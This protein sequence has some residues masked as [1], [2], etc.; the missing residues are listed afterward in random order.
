V[1]TAG[2]RTPRLALA[3]R[4]AQLLDCTLDV[5]T[6]KGFAAVNIEAI[7]RRA[8]V[9]RP[10]IYDTFG[11]L[12]TLLLALI[13]RADAA[14]HL[15]LHGILGSDPP[16]GADPERF[17]VDSVLAFL[18]AVRS[19]PRTWRLVLMPPR[20]DSP[21]LQTRIRLAR[22]E[23]ADRVKALLDW[24]V[25]SL[26][27]PSGLD[28]ELLARLIVAASE[29]A[30]R[31]MLAHPRR[32]PPERLAA[33]AR[34]LVALVPTSGNAAPPP[35]AAAPLGP[36]GPL[37]PLP[38]TAPP[39]RPDLSATRPAG[40]PGPVTSRHRVPQPERREQLLD[41]TLELLAEGGF[42]ALSVE[43]IARGTGVNRVVVY[44]SFANL[45]VLLTALMHREDRR[46][47]VTL[48]ELI[49][50]EPTGRPAGEILLTV[51]ARLLDA[52][53]AQPQTW[54]VALLRPE[55]APRA[56]QK[57]VNRR[58][59]VLA[60]RIEPLVR[61]ALGEPLPGQLGARPPRPEVEAVARMLLTF[62]EE[63]ARLALD[64]PDYP[65]ERLLHSSRALLGAMSWPAR[66]PGT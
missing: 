23:I 53:A 42:A 38:P 30:A 26:G 64:D 3:D 56:L 47:R 63:Q 19:D 16:A 66:A 2:P 49:P 13:D 18:Q 21:E 31:L 48:R 60:Q 15:T 10:V 24:G 55:S 14:A 7:A 41:V 57:I 17:L 27:G 1:A 8:G 32:F 45:P 36:L 50:R 46:I 43:A 9:T 54:R 12:D 39:A 62:G 44:R 51:L 58:R 34:E 61:D 29:D 6:E 37:A 59:A 33:A 11:D 5:L 20:G 65:P 35:A 28:H 25:P 40:P 4:R 22:R 52:V